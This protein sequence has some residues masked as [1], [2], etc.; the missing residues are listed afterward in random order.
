MIDLKTLKSILDYDPATGIFTWRV[1][2]SKKVVAGKQAGGINVAGYVVIGIDGKT[3]YAHRLAWFYMTGDWPSQVDHEDNVKTNNRWSNLRIASHQQNVLNA[4]L[5]KNSTS[6]RKGVSW[7][8]GAGR[9]SA[10]IILDGKKRHLGLFDSPDEAHKSYIT[11]AT[12]AQPDF[13]RS[14]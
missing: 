10:Y 5:S 9:W 3:Y 6:G 4:K 13:A 11:A 8:K 1:K 7:H 14:K 12:A 2:T